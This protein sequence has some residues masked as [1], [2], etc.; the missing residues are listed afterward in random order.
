MMILFQKQVH[1]GQGF[2]V[3]LERLYN[4]RKDLL[5]MVGIDISLSELI[6]LYKNDRCER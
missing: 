3:M 6:K 5:K 1:L 4:E 2:E